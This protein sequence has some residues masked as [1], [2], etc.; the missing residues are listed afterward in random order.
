MKGLIWNSDGFGD[1]AKHFALQEA[2]RENKLAFAAVLETGI[3]NFPAPFL[4]QISGGSEYAWYSL[5][6]HGRCGGI[7]AGFDVREI[8]VQSITTGDFCVKF[9]VKNKVDGFSWRFR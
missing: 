7:L 3:S 5:P 6:P 9:Q 1:T 8:S 2:I 4:R